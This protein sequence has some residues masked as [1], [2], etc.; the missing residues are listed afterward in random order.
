MDAASLL[1]DAL[2]V[3]LAYLC[4]SVPFGVLAARFR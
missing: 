4:G 3:C 2:L 1:R